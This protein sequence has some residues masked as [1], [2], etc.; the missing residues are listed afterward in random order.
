MQEGPT[1]EE[2]SSRL[3]AGATKCGRSG[4]LATTTCNGARL[5]PVAR[6]S[7]RGWLT[8]GVRG[9]FAGDQASAATEG[10]KLEPPLNENKDAALKLHDVN[11][12][13]EEPH[14]PGQ[15]T[16]NVEAKNIGHRGSAANHGHLAFV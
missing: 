4:K 10:E 5:A 8:A 12:V 6:V 3:E 14:Q 16:G 11:Q 2:K 15:Q 1:D 7:H 9:G 13:D